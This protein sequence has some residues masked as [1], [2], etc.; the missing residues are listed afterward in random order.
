[1]ILMIFTSFT[2]WNLPA[3]EKS[4]D[5]SYA[6]VEI[7]DAL[8]FNSTALATVTRMVRRLSD[9]SLMDDIVHFAS[10]E[11]GRWSKLSETKLSEVK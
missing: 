6:K 7:R 9:Y 3:C 11:K 1:M 10:P 2:I 8:C 5:V 4:S